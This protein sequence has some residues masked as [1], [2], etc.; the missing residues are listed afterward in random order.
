MRTF[1]PSR[2][3]ILRAGRVAIAL[4]F[5]HSLL[6]KHAQATPAK[7]KRF[8]A[9]MH[10]DGVQTST[11]YP[12]STGSGFALTEPLKGLES[13][14]GEVDVLSGLVHPT[15][16]HGNCA[17][18]FLLGADQW[19]AANA[20]GNS[21]DVA[22]AASLNG[23]TVLK[24]QL[25]LSTAHHISSSLTQAQVSGGFVTKEGEALIS[26]NGYVDAGLPFSGSLK[27]GA[28]R[29]PEYNPRRVFNALFC[30]GAGTN[31]AGGHDLGQGAPMVDTKAARRKSVLDAVSRQGAA[32]KQRLGRYD[33]Q[34]LDE[35]LNGI[36][37]IEMRLAP[38]P[39]TPPGGG[40]PASKAPLQ[41]MFP[42]I[43]DSQ[44]AWADLMVDL[45][46]KAFEANL[47]AV[48]TL[49]LGH[50]SGG[51]LPNNVGPY[52]WKGATG[53]FVSH[54]ASHNRNQPGQPHL[55]VVQGKVAVFGRLVKLLK[56]TA[57]GAGANLLDGTLAY[58]VSDFGDGD[59]HSN[60]DP[61]ILLA[62]KSSGLVQGHTH[63]K[64]QQVGSEGV[65]VSIANQFQVP[66]PH[67]SQVKGAL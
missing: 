37:D 67:L 32:L 64:L 48:A 13:V 57:D 65:L 2:R 51:D 45:M 36:R 34:R 47:V 19:K 54:Y 56:S 10:C 15:Q 39:N 17:A 28:V 43:P 25:T 40:G 60:I 50:S 30:G 27:D 12:S 26:N 41:A 29:T 52:Q 53:G 14:I 11:F 46:V 42:G 5:F 1:E 59:A 61:P 9:L 44:N 22:I 58:Y 24:N 35:Y 16:Q 3:H 7:L 55:S 20:K 49:M 18:S 8:V 4:P 66:M 62:G 21:L 23:N 31:C 63:K 38:T 33:Q 6:P